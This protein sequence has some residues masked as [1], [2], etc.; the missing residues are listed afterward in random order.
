MDVL[1]D[2]LGRVT[3]ADQI[4]LTAEDVDEVIDASSL[5]IAPGLI[6]PHVHLREPSFEYKK[7]TIA[8]G[9]RSRG[10]GR[11]Y[12]DHGDAQPQSVPDSWNT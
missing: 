9:N 12:N 6:D 11:L 3:A 7:E 10:Q 2:D 1:V 5:L 4:D 8:S